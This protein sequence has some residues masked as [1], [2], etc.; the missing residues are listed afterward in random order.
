MPDTQRFDPTAIVR[1]AS[2]TLTV[3]RVFGEAYERDG[4]LVIPVAKVIGGTGSGGGT[5]AHRPESDTEPGSAGPASE[6]E[7]GGGGF[8]VRVRPVGVYVIDEHGTH[9]RPALDLNR[10]I[11]GGQAV[12][13][14]A[15]TVLGTVLAARG[16]GRL[17]RR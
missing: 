12:G 16:L 15:I 13:A 3:R 10:V 7:G 6:G 8:A 14:L 2:D 11:L 9:W 1:A 4:V 17:R 5:G